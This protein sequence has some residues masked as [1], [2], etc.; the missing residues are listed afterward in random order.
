MRAQHISSADHQL[1]A[2]IGI[3]YGKFSDRS[4][5][6]WHGTVPNLGRLAGDF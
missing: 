1:V 4:V 5:F 3:G 6:S 2:T